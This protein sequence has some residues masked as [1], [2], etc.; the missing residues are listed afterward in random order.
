MHTSITCKTD[1]PFY[2]LQDKPRLPPAD[3][4]PSWHSLNSRT[5][6]VP[7]SLR[8]PGTTQHRR[9]HFRPQRYHLY[10]EAR[11]RFACKK[12]KVDRTVRLFIF[13]ENGRIGIFSF[14]TP[15][16]PLFYM[17]K[18]KYL[19]FACKTLPEKA[20]HPHRSPRP[21]QCRL[22][23]LCRVDIHHDFFCGPC[24][25][26]PII[27]HLSDI[28]ARSHGNQQIRVLKS[29]ISRTASE[30]ADPADI[31][32]VI[33]AIRS[34]PLNVERTGMP[35]F[36]TIARNN[37]CA[38]EMRMPLPATKTGRSLLLIRSMACET[39]PC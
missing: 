20:W 9:F 31:E 38:P 33:D 3:R 26:L 39:C 35:S 12:V 7:V 8:R 4:N 27:T 32:R 10:Q 6:S 21:A 1:Y 36:S 19:L 37:F 28:V 24:I 13:G 23:K 5:F 14:Q 34:T 30:C 22:F 16:M 2:H 29:K 18:F 11:L 15:G 17:S 25:R